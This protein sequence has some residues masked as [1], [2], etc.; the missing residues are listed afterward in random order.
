[1]NDEQWELLRTKALLALEK[2]MVGKRG[3]I[4]KSLLSFKWRHKGRQ[5]QRDAFIK[6]VIIIIGD[7]LNT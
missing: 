6:V 1:M 5:D 2:G 3:N 7:N 4:F